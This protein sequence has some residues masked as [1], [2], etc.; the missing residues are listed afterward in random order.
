[1]RGN[2][3][4]REQKKE[5][6]GERPKEKGI[7][8]GVRGEGKGKERSGVVMKTN[9]GRENKFERVQCRIG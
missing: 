4:R 7:R 8:R 6:E 1:M 2:D 9:K 5:R 3:R